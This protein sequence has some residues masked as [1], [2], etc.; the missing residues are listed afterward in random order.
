MI[1]KDG[2]TRGPVIRFLSAMRAAQVKEWLEEEENF[3]TI[4]VAFD[5]TS[6]FG[7]LTSI[8]CCVAGRELFMRLSAKTGDAMGMNMLSKGTE[9]ALIEIK[10]YFPDAEI[11]SLS[12]NYCTDKK[13]SAINW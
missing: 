6:R 11:I 10:K 8:K 12:G 3:Q 4:K 9:K 1:L 2:M 7:K 13:P 5:S